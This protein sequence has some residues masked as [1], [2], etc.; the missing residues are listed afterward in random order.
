MSKRI[1][2]YVTAKLVIECE[3]KSITAED[4]M[5][6]MDYS[7]ESSSAG[8]IVADTE[9]LDYTVTKTVDSEVE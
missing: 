7:F 4:I 3:D 8:A 2:M 6:D 5:N 1:I 9:I